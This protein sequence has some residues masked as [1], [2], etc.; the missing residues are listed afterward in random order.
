MTR[1]PMQEPHLNVRAQR[2]GMKDQIDSYLAQAETIE[3][4]IDKG[5]IAS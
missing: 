3:R 5:D 4:L 1:S 2:D